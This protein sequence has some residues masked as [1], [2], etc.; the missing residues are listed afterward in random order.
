QPLT[1]GSL[2]EQERIFLS[3]R[4]AD[5]DRLRRQIEPLKDE[6]GKVMNRFLREFPDERTDLEA[7]TDYLDSFLDLREHIRREDLP[8][9]E[10]RFKERL[11]EKVTQEIGLL[12]GA[13]QAE[14]AEIVSKIHQLNESLRQL[15]Y[16]PG[17][18]MRLEP[19]PVRDGEVVEFQDALKGCLAGTLEG[20]PEADEARFL[21]T[22]K[23]ITRLREDQRWREK[24]TDV[25]RWFDFAA[26]EIDTAT[27]SERGY[28]ED[29]TGQSGGEKAK[30]AFTILVAAI[31][32]QYDI[33]P[34]HAAGD[35]FHFVVVDE[36]FSKVD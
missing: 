33:D 17:T 13:F 36:M 27:G 5:A 8:R 9:H 12:N 19:R 31:A 16:R 18:H 22:E 21:R 6:L 10:Q 1:A 23:L 15:A 24:V 2:F 20:T 29:S 4:R 7:H 30:L 35:R 14:R 26:R 34:E 3:T 25:R 32:Y 11:N 28:Y